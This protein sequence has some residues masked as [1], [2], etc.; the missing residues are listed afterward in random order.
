MRAEIGAEG[1]ARYASALGRAARVMVVDDEP[2]VR[3]VLRE[4]LEV[5]GF[6]VVE[7]GDTEEALEKIPQGTFDLLVVDKNLPG[8]TGV[9]LLADLQTAS[10]NIPSVLITAFPSTGSISAALRAGARDYIAK[11]FEDIVRVGRRLNS[12]GAAG[13]EARVYRKIIADLKTALVASRGEASVVK[14]IGRDLFEHKQDMRLKTDVLLLQQSEVI[15]DVLC[16]ALVLEGISVEERRDVEGA[17]SLV[18]SAGALSAI[19]SLE[20]DNALDLIQECRV[21]DPLLQILATSSAATTQQGLEATSRGIVDLVMRSEGTEI[22]QVRAKRLVHGARQRQMNLFLIGTLIRYARQEGYTG[23]EALIELLPGPERALVEGLAAPPPDSSSSQIQ[24]GLG[25]LAELIETSETRTLPPPKPAGTPVAEPAPAATPAP[26]PTPEKAPAAPAA[27][28]DA[29]DGSDALAAN[30]PKGRDRRAYPRHE[31]SIPV[32]L[33][34]LPDRNQTM[35]T[36]TRD[37]S[38]QGLFAIDA[39]PPPPGTQYEIELRPKPGDAPIKAIGTVVRV[40]SGRRGGMGLL[41]E[42][43]EGLSL[44]DL[45]DQLAG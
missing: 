29:A 42:T 35:H 14:Q 40:D 1:W 41:V 22:L 26:D 17:L 37:I 18:S 16:G 3:E 5:N 32:K 12:V 33:T 28:A 34:R 44:Q 43:T 45:I 10:I 38:A 15:S 24:P 31:L 36:F 13:I 30:A 39:T 23:A 8:R 20:T 9:E 11:P 25:E 21:R 2:A 7:A 19:I 6:E 27:P 4:I